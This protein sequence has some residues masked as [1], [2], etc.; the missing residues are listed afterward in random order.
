MLA[1]TFHAMH[2]ISAHAIPPP[3]IPSSLLPTSLALNSSSTQPASAASSQPQP[4][5]SSSTSTPQASMLQQNDPRASSS[6]PNPSATPINNNYIYGAGNNSGMG[7]SSQMNVIDS[8]PAYHNQDSL[9]T[10][11]FPE[12]QQLVRSSPGI[13]MIEAK[14]FKLHCLQTPTGMKYLVS[15]TPNY[16]MNEITTLLKNVSI[17]YVDYA[18]KNPFYELGMPIRSELFENQLTKVVIPVVSNKH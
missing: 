18:L 13:T 4:T 8:I 7:S 3:H 10:L 9:N 16:P 2:A 11:L 12:K 15:T 1:S 5:G 6:Y 14:S 17:V